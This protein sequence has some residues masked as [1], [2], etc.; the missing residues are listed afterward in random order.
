M[1]TD[2]PRQGPKKPLVP[3][4]TAAKPGEEADDAKQPR[5][6]GGRPPL[7]SLGLPPLPS[8]SG[9]SLL[10]DL[11]LPTRESKDAKE[12]ARPSAPAAAARPPTPGAKPSPGPATKPAEERPLL[13]D[14]KE[15]VRPQRLPS[16]DSSSTQ[17]IEIEALDFEFEPETEPDVDVDVDMDVD[18]EDAFAE[19]PAPAASSNPGAPMPPIPPSSSSPGA[20]MPLIPPS[21][22]SPGLPV[23]EVAPPAAPAATPAT[24]PAASPIPVAPAPASRPG[25]TPSQPGLTQVPRAASTSQ[26]GLAQSPL[27]RPP[28]QP[29]PRA[30][31][32]PSGLTPLPIPP[33]SAAAPPPVS[34]STPTPGPLPSSPSHLTPPPT[35]VDPPSA[36]SSVPPGAPSASPPP[37]PA[38]DP[39]RTVIGGGRPT[40]VRGSAARP[41]QATRVMEGTPAPLLEAGAARDFEPFI[42]Q[43]KILIRDW[44]AELA[45]QP[46]LF[47]AARLHYEI[48]RFYEYPIGDL[49]KAATSYQRALGLQ[50]EHLPALVGARRVL[51]V[52]RAFA[53][54]LPLFDAE[55]RLTSDPRR[56]AALTYA[57]GRV[58]EDAMGK[59]SE[60]RQ[61]FAAAME[62]EPANLSVLKA[63]ERIDI[64]TANWRGL[65]QVYAKI[66]TSVEL[67]PRHRAAIICR[68]AHLL[69]MRL[70]DN[71]SSVELY[72]TALELDPRG[73]AAYAALKRLHH[74][75]SRWRELIH[76]LEREAEQT[77]DADVRAMA[78]YRVA[79]L[80]S[81]RLGN[82]DQA[83]VARERSVA[84]N[85]RSRLVLE[86]LVQTYQSAGRYDAMVRT[87]ERLVDL[88]SV[89]PDKI[90]ILF[91]IGEIYEVHLEDED[92]AVRWYEASLSIEPSYLPGLRALAKLYTRREAWDALI[93]MNL[94]E[95]EAVN[96]A[97]RKAAAHHRV[98]EI[99]E[100]HKGDAVTAM[101]HHA[102]ALS[103][104]P[105]LAA[106]FKA[107]VRLYTDAG[108]HHELIELYERGIDGAAN[109]AVKIAYLFRI[110][111]IYMDALGEP[112]QAIH[113]FRRILKI[114]PDH[115]GAI[116]ALQ[117]AADDSGRIKDLVEALELEASK[118]DEQTRVIALL[119]R[120]GELLDERLDDRDGALARFRRILKIDPK[121]QPALASSGRLYFRAGRWDDL[122][123]TYEQELA[124]TPPGR[125]AVALLH[126]MGKHAED[127]LGRDDQA[128]ECYRRAIKMDPKHEPSLEAL[129]RMLRDRERWPELVEVLETEFKGA[130]DPRAKAAAA[131]RIGRVYEERIG[132]AERALGAFQRA[133]EAMPEFRPALDGLARVRAL[134]QAWPGVVE[135]LAR[136]AATAR[137]PSLAIAALLRAGEIWS[138]HLGQADRAIAS[139]E[140]VLERDP[141]NLAAL[142]ALE[143]LYR[144]KSAWKSLAD[145]YSRQASILADEQAKVAALRDLARVQETNGVGGSSNGTH[146]AILKITANDYHALVAAERSSLMARDDDTLAGVDARFAA[147]SIDRALVGAHETR[148]GEALERSGDLR[149]AMAAYE[150]ALNH[151]AE[152]LAAM[153]GMNRVATT[154][155]DARALVFAKSRL[156]A[157]ERDGKIAAELLTEIA[158]IRLQRI[159]DPKGSLV[160]LEDA[161]E[162]WPDHERA[163]TLL[164]EMLLASE[165]APLLVEKLSQA[166]ESSRSPERAAELWLR[167]AELYADLLG[168]LA[169]GIAV[170]RRSLRERAN[171]VPSLILLGDL[172]VRNAQWVE[173]GDTFRQALN[174]A[175]DPESICVA[176][177]R[178]AMVLADH[179]NDLKRARECLAQVLTLRPDDREILLLATDYHARAGDVQAA[180]EGA[181]QLLRVSTGRAERIDAIIHLSHVESTLGRR[182]QALEV[183]VSA[184]VLEGPGG[185]AAREYASLAAGGASWA[186][187]AGAP[188]APPPGRDRGALP[189]ATYLEIA[190]V[191]GPPPAPERALNTLEQGMSNVDDDAPLRLELARRLRASGRPAEAIRTYQ[192]LLH[193]RPGS[194]PGWRGLQHCYAD[195]NRAYEASLTLA[196][197]CILGAASEGEAKS[198]A[199]STPRPPIGAHGSLHPDVYRS[200][201]DRRDHGAIAERLLAII[202]P[203]LARLYPMDLA[204]LGLN[205]KDKL[206]ARSG[207][208]V[209][210]LADRIA[211]IFVVPE[212][213]LYIVRSQGLVATH[214]FGGTPALLVP[215][216]VSRLSETQQIFVLARG[217]AD[218]ARGLH[219]LSKFKPQ[220]LMLILAAAA[221]TANPNFG[222]TLADGAALDE[223]NRR[224]AKALARKDRKTFEDATAAYASAPPVDFGAWVTDNRFASN[225]VAALIAGDLPACVDV[226]RQED[227]ALVYLDGEDLVQSSEHISDLLRYWCSD[228]A[229]EL[230]RRMAPQRA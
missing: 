103:L 71:R 131:Y 140:A 19:P 219:P 90:P 143:A 82:R 159:D 46:D 163:A 6:S 105:A 224:I 93:R 98:A 202:N 35:R 67:D 186:L 138:E 29:L 42:D 118:T 170:L 80:H 122:Y 100:T 120:A 65:E 1:S 58:L 207:N 173:A 39:K 63:I 99:F 228:S 184:I 15:L 195:I 102:Q 108:R 115:L 50:P 32:G 76:V 95:A 225:R 91:R 23:P 64:R 208:P 72:E 20:P 43:A 221:R 4:P 164:D 132:A 216:Q 227:P 74:G 54:A 62:L 162:R 185:Q 53:K 209:R 204:R 55:V 199:A 124:I 40:Q 36:P 111:D 203:S 88:L 154:L 2:D 119:H 126:T 149:G 89:L 153:Y 161:L 25:R 160:A 190:R 152:S 183:L 141:E 66:A 69:E 193:K 5:S 169:G 86:E 158:T 106:S 21:S 189:T 12:E 127:K 8:R 176:N 130:V 24:T 14:L 179:L 9:G 137:E 223:L 194:V 178:L 37:R 129:A 215:A 230:R 157:S 197:L 136:E 26:P 181:R 92:G 182:D 145:V 174:H 172:C 45:G 134:Q 125:A 34:E 7:S 28:S 139:Y 48:A 87:L 201:V 210:A 226:L 18:T 17:P 205:P 113:T 60:A 61:A 191:Q 52:Q 206:S 31:S 142:F 11:K 211:E 107:L 30:S 117:R 166:A 112:V 220:D 155:D 198:L 150:R 70:N 56:K 3:P 97:V 175:Q 177:T 192:L 83:I 84:E 41:A 22:S 16:G 167:I 222:S 75:Q 187:R 94:A 135:D 13:S 59:E 104:D 217:I 96:D 229:L 73:S 188:Q 78:Y 101:E 171:H 128:I 44:E 27:A 200:L 51:L 151:D 147:A 110:G 121:Y 81:E 133:L 33:P 47:R 38:L 109:K 49:D 116:H 68:R 168:N 165:Q 213:E 214:D 144:E 156:A 212:F 196:P 10:G 79:R 123:A 146:T 57:K 148:L 77:K 180:A 85:P 114:D 218:I